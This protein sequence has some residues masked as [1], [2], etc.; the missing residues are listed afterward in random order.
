MSVLRYAPVAYVS[1]EAIFSCILYSRVQYFF[2]KGPGSMGV[3]FLGLFTNQY[4]G[5][6]ILGTVMR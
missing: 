2:K 4:N 6:G 1:Q 5:V 3:I